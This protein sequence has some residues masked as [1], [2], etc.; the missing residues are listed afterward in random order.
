ME[1]ISA[2]GQSYVVIDDQGSFGWFPYSL[3]PK[4]TWAQNL[5]LSD[6]AAPF[7]WLPLLGTGAYEWVEF[8]DYEDLLL[9]WLDRQPIPLGFDIDEAAANAIET[10]DFR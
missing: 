10:F 9:L 5:D 4:R 8:Y 7:P 6:P 1:S 2:L 3:V